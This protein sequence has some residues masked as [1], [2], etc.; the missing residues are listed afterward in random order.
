MDL[1]V[2]KGHKSAVLTVIERST[3]KFLQSKLSSKKPDEVATAVYRLLIPYKDHVLTITTDNGVEF[4]NHQWIAK[5][6]DTTVYFADP[7][8]SGQKGGIEN[9][10]KLLR[11]YFPKGTDFNKVTQAE[12]DAVQHKINRRPREKLNFKSPK[13]IFFNLIS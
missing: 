13:N 3:N 5:K 8:C 11:Q 9:T 7:Y 1:V 4:M 10:N 2:G 6:L 12:L